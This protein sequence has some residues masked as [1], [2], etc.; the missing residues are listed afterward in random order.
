MANQ[1]GKDLGHV[2]FRGLS[3]ELTIIT[4]QVMAFTGHFPNTA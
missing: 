3:E 2:L 1:K 4:N